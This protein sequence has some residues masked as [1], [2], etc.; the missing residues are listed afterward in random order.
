[1]SQQAEE[2]GAARPG[3]PAGARR[4]IVA[5]SARC[6]DAACDIRPTN[7]R[8]A[9][10]HSAVEKHVILETKKYRVEPE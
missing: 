8:E 1:M 2:A 4:T 6:A 5:Y 10:V 9:H 3:V 7:P